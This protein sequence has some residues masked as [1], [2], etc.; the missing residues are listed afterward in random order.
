[1]DGVVSSAVDT[2]VRLPAWL[3]LT[4]AF[5]LPA[6]EAST[7]AGLVV[8]GEIAVLIGG[9]VAHEGALPLWSV[10]VAAVAGAVLGDQIGFLVG[11]RYGPRLTDRMPAR[12]RRSGDV[13]RALDLLRRRGAPA[14]ALGRWV[15]VLRALVPGLAGM[16]G[17]RRVPF[18]VANV[19]GGALWATTVAVLGYL[20]G[21]SYRAL[22]HRLGL[23]SEILLG[24]LV[25]GGALW[26]WRA[27][28]R[29]ANTPS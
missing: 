18:T 25:L 23:G 13:D 6:L 3:V 29:R 21:A 8:P 11:R 12:V 15:A 19:L 2:L 4:L 20:A 17:L 28:R 26:W 5:V 24:A 10:V 7:F 9:V 27:R 16:S 1:M 14:V 22:E